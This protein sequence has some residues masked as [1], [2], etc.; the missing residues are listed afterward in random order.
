MRILSVGGGDDG[1][2]A[3]LYVV[4]TTA[5]ADCRF[6]KMDAAVGLSNG[7]GNAKDSN[8]DHIT[9]RG[10]CVDPRLC[11]KKTAS[12]SLYMLVFVKM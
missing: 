12:F 1:G 8:I 4:V 6:T 3:V 10:D 5:G 2:V 11:Q 7:G 9:G